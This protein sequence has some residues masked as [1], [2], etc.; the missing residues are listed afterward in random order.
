MGKRFIKG[1]LKA[2]GLVIALSAAP[3][4]A[5]EDEFEYESEFNYGI[6]FNTNGGLIG[7]GMLKYA[8][9]MA[10]NRYHHFALEWVNVKHNKE[11]RRANRQTNNSFIPYKLNYFL[12]LRL[13]YGVEQVLFRKA[14][15]EGVQVNAILAGGPSFGFTKPYYVL[16]DAENN[17]VDQARSVP[18]DPQ[19]HNPS[20]IFGAGGPLDG[21]GNMKMQLGMHAK[22]GLSMEFG[23]FNNSVAGLEVGFM[24]E[25]F[26]RNIPIMYEAPNQRAFSS[27]YIT[28]Y[29]GDK[30]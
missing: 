25:R 21:I 26:G 14:P 11:V 19:R 7:G 3:L 17:N 1:L 15:E 2:L 18:Y 12:P 29:Y 16:Y 10:P 5:Q 23:I 28:L 13:S 20:F 8:T 9:R 27:F 24:A 4:Y 30:Y 6:N 22:L